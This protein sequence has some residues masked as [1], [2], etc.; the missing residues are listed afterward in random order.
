M[1]DRRIADAMMSAMDHL[2]RRH[3]ELPPTVSV[4]L[5]AAC[6]ASELLLCTLCVQYCWG[7]PQT[8][9]LKRCHLPIDAS[10]VLLV[11]PL[12]SCPMLPMSFI[13]DCIDRSGGGVWGSVLLG[14]S[15]CV[16]CADAAG[17]VE[18][19]GT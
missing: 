16:V 8:H 9:H 11:D 2:L 13:T 17:A 19:G 1:P 12:F 14:L 15:C 4:V 6:V 3:F 5:A 18:D 7:V 10:G